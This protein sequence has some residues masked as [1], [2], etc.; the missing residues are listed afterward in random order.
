MSWTFLGRRGKNLPASV[1]DMGL[2]LVQKDPHASKQLSL[3]TAT[4]EPML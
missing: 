2:I 4:T 3:C 1:V